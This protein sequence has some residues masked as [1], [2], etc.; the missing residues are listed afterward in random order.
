MQIFD[1]TK[2]LSK[3]REQQ[4]YVDQPLEYMF[5]F[6][7]DES[8]KP[9]VTKHPT[10]VKFLAEDKKSTILYHTY[11]MGKNKIMVRFTN[12]ADRFD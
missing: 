8:S 9:K 10:E 11:P 5:A 4:I 7:Y 1:Y 6:K 12:L 3:Q 2:G